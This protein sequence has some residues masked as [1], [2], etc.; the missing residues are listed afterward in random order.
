MRDFCPISHQNWAHSMTY[1]RTRHHGCG[2]T[3]V[4]RLSCEPHS[5]WQSPDPLWRQPADKAGV[6]RILRGLGAV[7]SHEMP[8]GTLRPIAYAS[9]TLSK[10]ERN[11]AQ[12]E[13][14]ALALVF[15]VKKF[16]DFLYA[17]PFTLVTDHKPLLAILGPKKGV[18]TLAAAR[19]QRWALILAAYQYQL[20][21]RS[22]D[23]HKNADMLSRLPLKEEDFTASE[24]PVFSITCA[25]SLPV[26]SRQ[27][28]EATRKDTVM[29]KVLSHTLH[30]WPAQNSDRDVQP[31][32][33]R[34]T[35]LSVEGGVLLWGQHSWYLPLSATGCLRSYTNS[36]QASIEW[37][38]LL[39]AM[40]GG[41]TSTQTL[42]GR[43]R[44]ATTVQECATLRRRHHFSHG[45]GLH[46]LGR[47]CI[48]TMPSIKGNISSW[49]STPT[50]SGR[51]SSQQQRRQQRRPSAFCC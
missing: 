17:R 13:K 27:I 40:S 10:L 18:P 44:L 42:K 47:E 9:R 16:H 51:R 39:A 6:R 50:P 21:F 37:R 30:G 19:M 8:D 14:E 22:T 1:W 15:G 3:N 28:A 20:Q 12:I 7:I 5:C 29:S 23:E 43:W 26:T 45:H 46:D 41:Q 32:F 24:E 4:K 31:Y 35:E 25:D 38:P 33:N 36:I 34:R 2:R 48:S 49:P 11:Y